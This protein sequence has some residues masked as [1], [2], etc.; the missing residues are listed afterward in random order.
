[1]FVKRGER[2]FLVLFLMICCCVPVVGFSQALQE[3]VSARE[4][5]EPV[6]LNHRVKDS[7]VF[8]ECLIPNFSFDDGNT[9]KEYHGYL[10]VY[11]DGEKYQTVERAA[12]VLRNLPEGKHTI[13]LDIMREDGGRYLSLEEMNVEIK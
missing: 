4:N 12:F 8:I 6:V 9:T 7:N 13:R 5:T 10:D 11:L 2:Q 3:N 1:M